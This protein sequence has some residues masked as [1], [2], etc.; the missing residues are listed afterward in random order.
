MTSEAL[1]P[2]PRLQPRRFPWA[3]TIAAGLVF[4]LCVGLGGWQLQRFQWKQGQLAR[5][6]ALSAAPVQPIGPVL[7]KAGRGEDVSFTRVVADCRPTKSAQPPPLE[8]MS[9]VADKGEWIARLLGD[10]RLNGLAFDGVTVDRGFVD[11]TRGS[12]NPSPGVAG[13]P[14]HVVGILI[15]EP[16]PDRTMFRNPAPYRLYAE[17]ETPAP[18]GVTPAPPIA[19]APGNLQ[20]VGAYA[21][22][23]FGLAGVVAC[24]YAA[25]LWRR[26]RP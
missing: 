4:V 3:L 22:T 11:S 8:S 6:A 21:P 2:G 16:H 9:I 5:I 20:Y 13:G 24:V 15:A 12:T 17:H 19:Q 26:R 14:T 18:P 25:M 10:C 23:W 1:G 7:A